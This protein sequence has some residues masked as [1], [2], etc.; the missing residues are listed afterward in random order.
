MT[1]IAGMRLQ[2]LRNELSMR[3]ASRA[4]RKAE[5]AA[6]LATYI[7]PQAAALPVP[8]PLVHLAAPAPAP[9]S[10]PP[11]PFDTA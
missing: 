6:R 3:G 10:A 1:D 9:A 4:G 2:E 7:V 11:P 5:L 8:I